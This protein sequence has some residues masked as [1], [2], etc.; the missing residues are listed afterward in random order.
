MPARTAKRDIHDLRGFTQTQILIEHEVQRLALACRQL[1]QGLLESL[2]HFG[3][4]EL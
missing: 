2:L 1:R 3:S 4:F